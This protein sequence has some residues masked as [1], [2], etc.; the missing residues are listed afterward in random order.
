[1]PTQTLT[2]TGVTRLITIGHAAKIGLDK[3][4]K[5]WEEHFRNPVKEYL[6]GVDQHELTVGASHVSLAVTQPQGRL[7]YSRMVADI[8]ACLAN[9]RIQ[10]TELSTLFDS[11]ILTVGDGRAA[12]EFL[13]AR[14]GVPAS[15]YSLPA[16]PDALPTYSLRWDLVRGQSLTEATELMALDQILMGSVQSVQTPSRVTAR[17]RS[18]VRRDQNQC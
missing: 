4:V 15:V 14:L 17:R 6:K 3:A 1:M 11:A 12:A 13:A 9:C 8:K 5:F 7:D 18:A 2:R 10:P 16:P